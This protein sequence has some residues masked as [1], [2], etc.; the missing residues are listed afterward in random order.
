MVDA[1]V[2]AGGSA[3]GLAEVPA[4]GLVPINGRPMVEYVVEALRRCP[5]IENVC[6]VMP[7]VHALKQD[8][9]HVKVVVASGNLPEVAKAGIDCL[10][11]KN[12][13]LVLSADIPLLTPEAVSDFLRRC[14]E[15]DAE[16]YYPIVRYGESEKRFP[17]VKRT[18][19]KLREGRFTGGNIGLVEAGFVSKNMAFIN[20]IYDLRKRPAKIIGVFG[21]WFLIRFALGWLSVSQ[22]EKRISQITNTRCVTVVTP[23]IEIGVDVDKESDLELATRVLGG[24]ES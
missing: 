21:Y 6:V 22:L 8:G 5:D 2:L 12:K 11:A 24:G 15:K 18:Y 4:K 20:Q 9:E 17:E 10:G 13:V 19:A 23:F 1:V 3:K 7:V 14:R 16:L